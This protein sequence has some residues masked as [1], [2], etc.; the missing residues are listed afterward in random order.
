MLLTVRHHDVQF[1]PLDLGDRHAVERASVQ[2]DDSWAVPCGLSY[3]HWH[4]LPQLWRRDRG[5][6]P[7]SPNAQVTRLEDGP[8]RSLTSG[9]E[10]A[11]SR[12][13]RLRRPSCFVN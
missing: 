1:V 8:H 2:D 6:A 13:R 11:R 5:K 7:P 12:R 3:A 9:G 4:I 10:T